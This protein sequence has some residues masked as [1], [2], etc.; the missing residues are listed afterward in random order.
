MVKPTPEV[1]DEITFSDSGVYDPEKLIGYPAK[2][3]SDP[4]D[5]APL[6]MA[7]PTL[8]MGLPL[9]NTVDEPPVIFTVC[10]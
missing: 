7:S 5:I 3:L 6:S 10:G 9:T 1:S 4:V 8:A 2:T